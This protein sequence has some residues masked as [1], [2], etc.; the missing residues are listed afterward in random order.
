MKIN[1]F[2]VSVFFALAFFGLFAQ[3]CKPNLNG[4]YYFKVNEESSAVL[5]FFAN[6]EVIATTSNNKYEEV[7]KY[8]TLEKK[9]LMLSGK[10]KWK[11]C[12]SS[13]TLGG[14]TGKQMYRVEKKNE[15]L[16]VNIRDNSSAQTIQR[17]YLFYANNK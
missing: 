17:T 6:G 1:K 4:F 12:S 7:E 11:K 10:Y 13:F 5:R 15:N 8:F 16:I 3:K 14:D 2:F 9:D